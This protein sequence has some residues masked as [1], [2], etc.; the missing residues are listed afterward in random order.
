M[1]SA[2]SLQHGAHLPTNTV[3]GRAQVTCCT[4]DQTEY[5]LLL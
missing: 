2:H 3:L 4:R 5:G 1:T